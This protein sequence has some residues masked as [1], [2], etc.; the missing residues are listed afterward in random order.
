MLPQL[1]AAT[2]GLDARRPLVHR[3]R[4][5]FIAVGPLVRAATGARPQIG[6]PRW[7]RAYP[8]S[9]V[10][11]TFATLPALEVPSGWLSASGFVALLIPFGR[12]GRRLV[13]ATLV[14]DRSAL[15]KVGLQPF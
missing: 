10:V 6:L 1:E 4:P 5:W 12:A 13:R 3:G 14:G 9:M 7:P 2:G 15:A 11:R 8:V